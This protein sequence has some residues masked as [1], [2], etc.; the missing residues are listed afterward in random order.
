M[1]NYMVLNGSGEEMYNFLKSR[2]SNTYD[3]IS[4]IQLSFCRNVS[5]TSS[6]NEKCK[7]Q[8]GVC[9][10]ATIA[11]VDA[12]YGIRG[13][14]QLP[15]DGNGDYIES[16]DGY[17]GSIALVEKQPASYLNCAL[18][19]VPGN[20]L[21][22]L[23]SSTS[24]LAYWSTRTKTIS[25]DKPLKKSNGYLN[26]LAISNLEKLKTSVETDDTVV[27]GTFQSQNVF[28]NDAIAAANAT[29][30]SI[31]P[32][33]TSYNADMLGEIDADTVS[34][35]YQAMDEENI[36]KLEGN[37]T[38]LDLYRGVFGMPYQF[39]PTTDA[40]LGIS[41]SDNETTGVGVTYSEKIL[42]RMPLLF[43][44]PG[45]S[46]FAAISQ[47]KKAGAIQ[48]FIESFAD[49]IT[50][51][52]T[53]LSKLLDGYEGKFY[54]MNYA[55][56]QY[57][58]YV[59]PMCR[60]GAIYLGLHKKEGDEIPDDYYKIDSEWV[61]NYNWALN[62]N[63]EYEYEE[64]MNED[65]NNTSFSK[66]IRRGV[67]LLYYKSCIPFYINS[68][69]TFSE[70]MSNETVESTLAATINGFSDKARE[71]QFIL[72]TSQ[73]MVASQYSSI[74]SSLAE[75]KAAVESMVNNISSGKN[76]IFSTLVNSVSTIVKGGRL[77]FPNIWSNSSVSKS[78]EIT[79]RLTT[80]D[81][82]KKSW[83]LN[84]Y[85]P[86]CHLIAFVL[87]HGEY[88]NGYTSPFLV[89]AF[90]KGMFNIDMG[91]ITDMSITKGK[92]G[93]WT[94]DALPT[95]VEVR[96]TIQDLYSQLSITPTGQLLKSNVMQN[97]SEMD[98]LANLC[99][100][101]INE[102][103]L[104]RMMEMFVILN[105]ENIFVDIIPDIGLSISQAINNTLFRGV[106]DNNLA[107]KLI[108]L[109]KN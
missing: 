69:V 59:N 94:K 51:A 40:R 17:N 75:S 93:G 54:T 81:N 14:V 97:I 82:D 84:V 64:E 3:F 37:S 26:L 33:T 105:V 67:D 39:L 77:I 71:L 41:S 24:D 1:A 102:P 53:Q 91:I 8:K 106:Y 5:A 90:Y 32:I 60:M 99:G 76:N 11:P 95:V 73:N 7:I 55:Y 70:S 52:E 85:V 103:D 23:F 13:Y 80:P 6:G 4:V 38:K 47:S 88:K 62:G 12:S 36:S 46:T 96:M 16:S 63:E 78:Y 30:T 86:L 29:S 45:E 58:K 10:S 56:Y 2:I 107:A 9:F 79:I 66:V 20:N 34:W 109:F 68:D 18:L 74:E 101:N 104:K 15:Q 92:E 72:G 57:Y 100:V 25:C 19:V 48:Q 65:D 27:D 108:R 98:Y 50:D 43:L 61:K 89:K 28:T 21:S 49:G 42:S 22:N 31:T 44:T 87:P 35:A 83:W